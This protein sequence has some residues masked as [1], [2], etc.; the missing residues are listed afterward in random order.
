MHA[1][2]FFWGFYFMA[3]APYLQVVTVGGVVTLAIV[4]RVLF[5]LPI[6]GARG[7]EDTDSASRSG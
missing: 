2:L 3:R 7:V 4:A 6:A 1:V 5:A